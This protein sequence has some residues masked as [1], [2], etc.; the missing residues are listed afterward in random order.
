MTSTHQIWDKTRE[1]ILIGKHVWCNKLVQIVENQ[2]TSNDK[3]Q[4]CVNMGILKKSVLLHM[5][6]PVQRLT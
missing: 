1:P 2:L 5:Q 4:E 3:Q 6:D